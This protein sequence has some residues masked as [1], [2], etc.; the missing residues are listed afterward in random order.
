VANPAPS[1]DR[2]PW[3]TEVPR[4]AAPP[5]PPRTRWEFPWG[6]VFIGLAFAFVAVAAYYLGIRKATQPAE[7]AGSQSVPLERPYE[8]PVP[9]PAAP[10]EEDMPPPLPAPLQ[11]CDRAT[12]AAPTS[13]GSL[14]HQR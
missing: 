11:P 12:A 13:R 7:V 6:A 4:T 5:P 1:N 2:L 8:E 10:A 9:S 14:G 3:L